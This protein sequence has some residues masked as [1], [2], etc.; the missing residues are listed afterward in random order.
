MNALKWTLILG[1]LLAI[2]VVTLIG[3]VAHG[4]AE[5]SFLPRIAAIYFPL[6][7]AWFLLAS[8]LGLFKQEIISNRRGLWRPAVAMLYA[9]P[10]A[11]VLRGLILDSSII[12]IFAV[13]LGATSALGMFLWRGL[14]FLLSR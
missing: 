5:L 7:I 8:P 2:A 10:F 1:D 13:I 12:P 9:A 14:Y 6:S 3:F 4:A 11:A